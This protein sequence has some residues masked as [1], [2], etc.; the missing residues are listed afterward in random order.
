MYKQIAAIVI[1]LACTSCATTYKAEGGGATAKIRFISYAQA[2]TAVAALGD[3]HCSTSGNAGRIAVLAGPIAVKNK[4]LGMLGGENVNLQYMDEAEVPAG[5]P[6]VYVFRANNFNGFR[7]DSAA[8][9]IPEPSQQYE[10]SFIVEEG[11]CKI[12]LARLSLENGSVQR[13][14]QEPHKV[15]CTYPG[16]F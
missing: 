9:F 1:G 13:V 7:C 10:T 11:T 16:N 12:T 14:K 4:S 2:Q 6:F 5:R 15:A 8:S 3:E